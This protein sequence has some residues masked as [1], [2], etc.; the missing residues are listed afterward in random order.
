M[1]EETDRKH[2]TTTFYEEQ[3]DGSLKAVT[4]TYFENLTNRKTDII[5]KVK[6]NHNDFLSDVISCLDVITKHEAKVLELTITVD[7]WNKPSSIVKKYT[8][9]KENFGKRR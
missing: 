7:E 3:E 6:T 5:K 1:S 4:E 8:I 9:K 2:V